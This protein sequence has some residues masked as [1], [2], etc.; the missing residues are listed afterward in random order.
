MRSKKY[1]FIAISIF[2]IILIGIY[3]LNNKTTFIDSSIPSNDDNLVSYIWIDENGDS[4]EHNLAPEKGSGYKIKEITCKN[5]NGSWNYNKWGLDLKNITGKAK[6]NLTFDKVEISNFASYI[7]SLTNGAPTN[8]T[9]EIENTNLAYD[10]F[11]NLRYVGGG[12][13]EGSVDP[14]NYLFFNC[15]DYSNQNESTCER[16]RIIGVFNGN[17]KIIRNED[18]GSYSWDSSDRYTNSGNGVNEWSQADLKTELNGLYYNAQSG[19][20]YSSYNNKTT[21]C[22]F[23]TTGLKND[24]TRNAIANYTWNTAAANGTNYYDSGYLLPAASYYT[25][26]RGTTT[27]KNC[28]SSSTCDD[29]VTRKTTWTGK[30]ALMYPS[31]YSYAVGGRVR[32]T[33]LLQNA[34][35]NTNLCEE[36]DWLHYSKDQWTLSPMYGSASYVFDSSSSL[37]WYAYCNNS[38]RPVVYL[39]QI[40]SFINNGSDGSYENPY[41]LSI[42]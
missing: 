39:K 21:A 8:S 10:D 38:V 1:I 11:G 42:N 25:Y 18:I 34:Q 35:Y 23:T 41:M 29:E 32:S 40:T 14:N 9:D 27:G 13:D 17:V 26:E 28:T 15:N 16:W 22:D 20:C 24:E 12:T 3:L 36:N 2:L 5:A 19:N 33:C 4:S 6:C 37:M 30:V 31:D 7:T